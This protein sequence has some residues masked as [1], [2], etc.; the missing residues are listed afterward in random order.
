VLRIS[1]SEE[2][3]QLLRLS[4]SEEFLQPL[5]LGLYDFESLL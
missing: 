1:M 2:L 4:M 5:A 3:R